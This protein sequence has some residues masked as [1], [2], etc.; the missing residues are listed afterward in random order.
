MHARFPF[1]S[2]L[3]M[4][5]AGKNFAKSRLSVSILDSNSNICRY[6][7]LLSSL[8]RRMPLWWVGQG[9]RVY[10]RPGFDGVARNDT[11]KIR[12][13]AGT[14]ID[15]IGMPKNTGIKLMRRKCEL[16]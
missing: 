3:P 5:T 11:P 4:S 15:I 10:A 2:E 9:G 13:H 16:L 12:Q 6:R 8:S 1:T 14:L 7:S